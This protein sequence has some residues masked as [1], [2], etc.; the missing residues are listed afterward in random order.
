MTKDLKGDMKPMMRM[1]LCCKMAILFCLAIWGCEGEEGEVELPVLV[2]STISADSAQNDSTVQ[3]SIVVE[4]DPR[5]NSLRP[6]RGPVDEETEVMIVGQDFEEGMT[7]R[8]GSALSP[9]NTVESTNHLRVK[10]PSGQAA[11]DVDVVLTWPNQS[12][13]IVLKSAFHYYV[14]VEIEEMSPNRGPA[15]G[16]TAFTITGSGF[17][18]STT[19]RI[20]GK[21]A[22]SV[23][24]DDEGLTI[25]GLTPAG[26]GVVDVAVQNENGAVRL[27]GGFTYTEPLLIADWTP[28]WSPTSGGA[29]ITINGIGLSSDSI[30]QLGGIEASDISS[31]LERTVLRF[32]TPAH[33]AGMVDLQVFNRNGTFTKEDALL[34][35]DPE[36][37]AFDVQ[38][39]LPNRFIKRGGTS[40]VIGGSGFL[41]DVQVT[42][43][44][45]E[46]LCTR[47]ACSETCCSILSCMAPPHALGQVAVI[48]EQ[49]GERRSLDAVYYEDVDVYSITPDHGSIAG[50]TLIVL[51]GRG[52]DEILQ[53]SLGGIP[54]QQI[55]VESS[56]RATARTPKNA[57]GSAELRLWTAQDSMLEPDAYT[58]I[59]PY[60]YYAGPFGEPIEWT[61]NV[62]VRDNYTN[63]PL[64]G[65]TVIASHPDRPEERL[66]KTTDENGLVTFSEFD[67]PNP[68][69]L[70]AAMT[71]YSVES[72]ERITSENLSLF[73]DPFNPEIPDPPNPNPQGGGDDDP[74]KPTTATIKGYLHGMED[75]PKP[76]EPGWQMAA[77]I[78]T[79]H[80]SPYNRTGLPNPGPY[81]IL[82]SDGPFSIT[83]R[84]GQLAVVAVV[85][86]VQTE[87]LTKYQNNIINYWTMRRSVVPVAMGLSRY[88]SLSLGSVLTDVEITLDQAM[89]LDLPLNLKDPPGSGQDAPS[90]NTVDGYL[91]LSADGY[92]E[93]GSVSGQ[94]E[95]LALRH[96]PDLSQWPDD[97]HYYFEALAHPAAS[98]YALPYS[99]SFYTAHRFDPVEGISIGPFAPTVA[100][101]SPLSGSPISADRLLAW[102]FHRT[103]NGTPCEP[104]DVLY[105]V[106]RNDMGKTIW[107]HFAP[108]TETSYAL[109]AFP[110]DLE[111]TGLSDG[112]MYM[113]LY[114]MILKRPFDYAQFRIND[115]SYDDRSSY[116]V[117]Q[118]SFYGSEQEKN[119]ERL[120]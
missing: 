26:E 54:L 120:P 57:L 45:Q 81:G 88:R 79:S 44:G 3:D 24:I 113:T 42:V 84:G 77:F 90:L 80:T 56:E 47:K 111:G 69:Q 64:V 23:K 12:E 62:S 20:G 78:E 39:L 104:A 94:S 92:I 16:G 49:G 18:K 19:V 118:M 109:P 87:M 30:V 27:N 100:F 116:S 99:Y 10:A 63:R 48:V 67:L 117:Q 101:T 58:Y 114:A 74:P 33:D 106:V 61:V 32:T 85:G 95:S 71:D 17:I 110:A 119:Y 108:G 37:P 43:D 98:T 105:L 68:V 29:E 11:G 59:T 112:Y 75:W 55:H 53:G 83:S 2:D 34:Y 115:L 102:D 51:Q 73:L 50:D 6:N 86:Y 38:S 22:S 35:V 7:V 5:V 4:L 70:V 1:A 93:L 46:I 76:I 9:A 82:F 107:T 65:A 21:N 36:N 103:A 89:D 97:A 28:Q 41:E 14:P 13:P 72:F 66:L 31:E 25:T 40:F 60:S 91:D 15:K 96:L 52:F 8:F